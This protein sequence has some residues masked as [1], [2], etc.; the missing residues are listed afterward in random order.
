MRPR[1]FSIPRYPQCRRFAL[2]VVAPLDHHLRRSA[3]RHFSAL[4][5]TGDRWLIRKEFTRVREFS[6]L[7]QE[8][9]VRRLTLE[10]RAWAEHFQNSSP[11]AFFHRKSLR[12]VLA[13]LHVEYNGETHF[14]RGINS[15]VSLPTGTL[16][17]ERA[18]IVKARIDIPGLMRRHARGIAVVEVPGFSSNEEAVALNNPLPP[19]GACRE[20]LEKIQEENKDFYV[21]T[22]P[23][24]TFGQVHERLL[25]WSEQED[26]SRPP[27]LGPW[28]CRL[29]GV[30]NLPLSS[31]CSGCDVSRFSFCYNR[32][33][34]QERFIA[35]LEALNLA[36]PVKLEELHRRL[37]TVRDGDPPSVAEIQTTLKRLML[38]KEDH[39]GGDKYG[40]MVGRDA[41]RRFFVTDLGKQVLLNRPKKPNR[42]NHDHVRK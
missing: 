12:V 1:M 35:C 27:E 39:K 2:A 13:V 15:E 7:A 20:W 28:T 21:L 14:I 4:G 9:A 38:E 17:A 11:D 29:C 26:C 40:A 16:C 42:N 22:F 24:L 18:A 23:D 32:V 34:T 41:K 25:F 31:I 30:H 36:G 8:D 6:E 37:C 3:L 33:P 5:A 10:T 19:C